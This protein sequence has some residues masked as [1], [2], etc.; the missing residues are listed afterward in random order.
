MKGSGLGAL[1]RAIAGYVRPLA[2]RI[3]NRGYLLRVEQPSYSARGIGLRKA[4]T[5]AG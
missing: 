2:Q 5:S 4:P 1:G 3:V